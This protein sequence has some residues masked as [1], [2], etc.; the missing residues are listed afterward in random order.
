MFVALLLAL[1]RAATAGQVRQLL[2]RAESSLA[3]S[4]WLE[5]GSCGGSAL[6]GCR[7][8]VV[9]ARATLLGQPYEEDG[10]GIVERSGGDGY[11]MG[12]VTDG[13]TLGV[14]HTCESE[15]E[16]LPQVCVRATA[17]QVQRDDGKPCCEIAVYIRIDTRRR[18]SIFFSFFSEFCTKGPT[19]PCS[20][21]KKI[22]LLLCGVWRACACIQ[23]F[24]VL[25][26]AENI[27]ASRETIIFFHGSAGPESCVCA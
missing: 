22:S 16:V 15:G 8:E 2:A 1:L 19:F 4:D 3:A 21:E 10:C 20:Y 24:S 23:V 18:R 11:T 5:G 7:R 6:D 26:S 9:T 12:D 17:R 14:L 27:S 25:R 13:A